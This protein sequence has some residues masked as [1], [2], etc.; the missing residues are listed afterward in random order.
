[1]NTRLQV[2]HPITE[3]VT[4]V[5]LVR[6]Q[7]RIARGER[8]D[9]DPA[10]AADARTATRSSAASTPRIPT[11]TS[12]RRRAASSSCA[13]PAGPGIRD[14]S[15]A[16]RRPRRADLLRP[17]DLEARRVGRGS[18][19]RDRAHAPRARRV[20]RRRHQDDGAVFHA[21]CSR[22]RSSS[23]GAFH[24][25][26]LDEVLK[27]RNGRPFV[28]PTPEVEDVAAIAAALQAVLSPSTAAADGVGG[29]PTAAARPLARAG[30]ALEGSALRCS[31]EVEVGGRARQVA[32][33]RTG[34]GFAV[35]RRRTHLAG[36]RG[37]HRRAH[38]VARCGQR[39]RRQSV[40]SQPSSPT[41][42]PVS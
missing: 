2:E 11:T 4:G 1:M 9:L 5:D 19:A 38:A 27:A 34:D 36:R 29:R 37:A 26:Y 8:L 24:T 35:T 15:G 7:I 42:R 12:C 28:E 32:V 18:A 6:W 20:P 33:T 10:R 30:R 22:S 25:T 23:T 14:D 16:D 21:G 39:C 3:M 31:Y 13:R 40:R 17:D 41:R